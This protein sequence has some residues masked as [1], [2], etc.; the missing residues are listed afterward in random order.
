MALSSADD[1]RSSPLSVSSA[2]YVPLLSWLAEKRESF[3]LA[4]LEARFGELDADDHRE[5]AQVLAQ[6]GFLKVLWF[7]QL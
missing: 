3:V 4:D 6:A 7:P 2:R 5:L 1:V